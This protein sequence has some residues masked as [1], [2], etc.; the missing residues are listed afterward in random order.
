MRSLMTDPMPGGHYN[1]VPYFSMPYPESQPPRLAALAALHGLAAPGASQCRVLELGCA[2]G[3]NIIPLALRFPG[4][5]FRGVD[6]AE[7]HVRDAEARIDAL[8]L[9]NIRVEQ[10]DI[11][12]LDLGAERFD[13][14]VCH[15]VLSWVPPPVQDAMLRICAENLADN[16]IAYVSYN[17]HPGWQLRK[18][19]RDMM[20]YRAGTEGDPRLRVGKARGALDGIAK[21]A[22]AG[23][24][25]VELLRGE[26]EM[27]REQD[28]SYILSEYLERENWP[29]YFHD[30]AARIQ[31][32]GLAYLCDAELQHCVPD[33]IGGD[34]AAAVRALAGGDLIALEQYMDFVKGRSFRR[35]LLVKAAQAGKTDRSLQPARAKAMHVSG[36]FARIGTGRGTWAF[37]SARGGTL[38]TGNEVV[39]RA[40][41]KLSEVFPATRT[42]RELAAEVRALDQESTILDAVFTLMLA[43]LVDVSSVPLRAS[44]AAAS[45]PK[46]KAGRLARLD[47]QQGSAWTTDPAHDMVPLDAVCAVLLPFLD[48]LHDREALKTKLLAAAGEG[49]LRLDEA[50][51]D[52]QVAA[53]IAT[54]AAAALLE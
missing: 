40:L 1:A 48:G 34:A 29:C 50:T 46:P 8:G 20:L 41:V 24:P 49:R 26:A 10:G 52:A 11:A 25:F 33:T 51:A 16:G 23:G 19:M 45:R 31:T 38:T 32:F 4:S 14:I 27:L 15:G 47:A 44:A 9:K 17:V 28:D 53:A 12:A 22:R 35:S 43:G 13:Y 42:A 7:R 6:L 30:F 36:R 37:E 39:R 54:L 3:G 2:S 5:R 21:A 18:V